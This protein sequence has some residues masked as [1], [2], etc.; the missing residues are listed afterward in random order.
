MNLDA[1]KLDDLAKIPKRILA[2]ALVVLLNILVWFLGIPELESWD[3]ASQREIKRIEGEI[4]QTRQRLNLTQKEVASLGKLEENYRAV[5]EQGL[6]APQD[7]L[8]A[9]R[10]IEAARAASRLG[11][12]DVKFTIQAEKF[13]PVTLGSANYEQSTS[14][15]EFSFGAL[16]DRDV[17]SFIGT[18]SASMPGRIVVDTL[19]L[20]REGELNGE[21]LAKLRAGQTVAL[22]KG[23]A[24]LRWITLRKP[25]EKGKGGS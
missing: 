15:I 17:L 24:K 2:A 11:R 21:T 9:E 1:L 8:A 23:E 19:S 10:I 7:R 16:A 12:D 20:R 13:Q 4:S 3:E 25:P 18:F 5:L 6:T 14:I 22:V